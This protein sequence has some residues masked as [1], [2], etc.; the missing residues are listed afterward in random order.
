MNECCNVLTQLR[1]YFKTTI[2]KLAFER[3]FLHEL[4]QYVVSRLYLELYNWKVCLLYKWFQ[5]WM[6]LIK[7]E[8]WEKLVSKEL[9]L[10]GCYVLPNCPHRLESAKVDLDYFLFWENECFLQIND[11]NQDSIR[12]LVHNYVLQ[13][14]FFCKSEKTF[15]IIIHEGQIVMNIDYAR[16]DIKNFHSLIPS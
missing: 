2:T 7:F 6:C 12:D 10:K 1:I 5:C 11:I 3:F 16:F 15:C 8:L 4:I 14:Q 13:F 9:H